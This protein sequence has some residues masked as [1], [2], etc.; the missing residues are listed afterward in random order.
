MIRV[1]I[2]GKTRMGGGWCIGALRLKGW[3]AYRLKAPE[4][5]Y[6]W[7]TDC[8]LEVGDVLEVEGRRPSE[9]TNPH[10]EN[11]IVE[12]YKI[13][14]KYGPTLADDIYE[15][16]QVAEALSDLFEGCIRNLGTDR[17]G[18]EPGHAPSFSTQFWVPTYPLELEWRQYQDK[19]RKPYYKYRKWVIPYVGTDE[20]IDIIPAGSLVRLS[21][22]QWFPPDAPKC[23][24]QLSG[25]WLASEADE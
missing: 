8:G 11:Y 20:P 13:V 19:P 7:P 2:V 25:W 15:N 17:L 6:S 23:Y 9:T 22:A 16:C 1:V 21:L 3:A 24:L 4:G 10:T 5:A 12:S 18:V 14:G